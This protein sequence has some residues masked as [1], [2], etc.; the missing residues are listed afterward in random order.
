MKKNEQMLSNMSLIFNTLKVSN[1]TLIELTN[2]FIIVPTLKAD[3]KKD[4]MKCGKPGSSYRIF[5][6]HGTDA[7]EKECRE[8]CTKTD[9]CVAMSGIWGQWCIGC[10]V[11]LNTAHNLAK[12]FKKVHTKNVQSGKDSDI[13][14]F[15]I[16][17]KNLFE[18]SIFAVMIYNIL[19]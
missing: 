7:Q 4:N 5:E 6:L 13:L 12:A 2:K 15:E 3:P 18:P 16:L 17:I 11:F 10:T 9:D 14:I 8:K 19:F 1:P